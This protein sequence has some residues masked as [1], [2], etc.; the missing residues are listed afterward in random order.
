[1]ADRDWTYPALQAFLH[2][3]RTRA[4]VRSEIE[5]M[6]AP[7]ARLLVCRW[8]RV[9]SAPH[10]RLT[11][12]LDATVA[13]GSATTVRPVAIDWTSGA[14]GSLTFSEHDLEAAARLGARAV[15]APFTDLVRLGAVTVRVSPFDPAFPSLARLLDPELA[16][17]DLYGLANT[18]Q[19]VTTVRYRPNERHVLR[20]DSTTHRGGSRFAKLDRPGHGA[21]RAGDAERFARAVNG[22][23]LLVVTPLGVVDDAVVYP[24]TGGIPL[25]SLDPRDRQSTS[26]WLRRAG[27]ALA[28][29]HGASGDVAGAEHTVE[30]ELLI[31]TRAV[32]HLSALVIEWRTAI[33]ELLGRLQALSLNVDPARATILHGDVKLDHL[34]RRRAELLMID[35]DRAGHGEASLD[36]GNLLADVRWWGRAQPEQVTDMAIS[37]VLVGYDG[38]PVASLRTR[39][40]EAIGLLRIAGRRPRLNRSNWREETA[41]LLMAVDDLVARLEREVGSS[42]DQAISRSAFRPH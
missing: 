11:V 4:L 28:Q 3:T 10:E 17:A 30:H 39:L 1:M 14:V 32:R 13:C 42:A 27:R 23:G 20:F 5:A 2:S 41:G 18:Q 12:W 34:H 25:S 33:G 24:S 29:V 15:S 26:A 22:A 8:R 6:L 21:K 19:E 40:V 16:P 9:K 37:D 38:S 7:T 31:A 36:V 35:I